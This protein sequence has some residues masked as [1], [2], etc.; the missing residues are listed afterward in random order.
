MQGTSGSAPDAGL[1]W[2]VQRSPSDSLLLLS[3]GRRARQCASLPS[4]AV[5]VTVRWLHLQMSVGVKF[6]L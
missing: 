3:L 4:L 1:G 5:V 2:E 6:M